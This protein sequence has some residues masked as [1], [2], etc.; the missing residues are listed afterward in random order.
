MR[1]GPLP[2]LWCCWHVWGPGIPYCLACACIVRRIVT[3]RVGGGG[4]MLRSMQASGVRGL[5]L[6]WL[7]SVWRQSCMSSTAMQATPTTGRAC[8]IGRQTASRVADLHTSGSFPSRSGAPGHSSRRG[9]NPSIRIAAQQIRQ[10]SRVPPPSPTSLPA[11]QLQIFNILEVIHGNTTGSLAR[12]QLFSG[13]AFPASCDAFA[14]TMQIDS[15]TSWASWLLLSGKLCF[16]AA[17][18]AYGINYAATLRFSRGLETGLIMIPA[19]Y[20]ALCF[21]LFGLVSCWEASHK[22]WRGIVPLSWKE[23]G[24]HRQASWLCCLRRFA[25]LWDMTKSTRGAFAW[26]A[27]GTIVLY[28]QFWCFLCQTLQLHPVMGLN[29]LDRR[30]MRR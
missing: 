27:A 24:L 14:A 22:W 17:F 8:T 26:G 11:A 18:T 16:S 13:A 15:L 20:G 19:L 4:I 23:V 28:V 7:G 5:C 29:S 25:G 6:G 9:G 12:C 21:M 30:C 1:M 10:P 3:A 2:P